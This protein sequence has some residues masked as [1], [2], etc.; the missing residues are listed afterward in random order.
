MEAMAMSMP[1]IVRIA[2]FT[3]R[4][5]LWGEI[6]WDVVT[7]RVRALTGE[8]SPLAASGLALSHSSFTR[9]TVGMS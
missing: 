3:A 2:W 5:R 1:S 8:R 4:N 6:L 7:S 9:S